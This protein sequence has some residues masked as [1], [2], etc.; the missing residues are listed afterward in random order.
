MQVNSINPNMASFKGSEKK[1]VENRFAKAVASVIVPGLG[2]FCDG[3]NTAGAAFLLGTLAINIGKGLCDD[4]FSLETKTLGKNLSESELV[5]VTKQV[6][7][8]TKIHSKILPILQIAY[9]LV[10]IASAI[11]AF[12][13]GSKKSTP[14]A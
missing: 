7:K 9:V 1:K 8:E 14:N 13:G 4:T 10:V 2:Q 12:T 11:N 3:R 6:E 5:K